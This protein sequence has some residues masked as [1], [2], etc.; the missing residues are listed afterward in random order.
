MMKAGVF[1]NAV[2]YRFY[3]HS[4]SQLRS[5]TCFKREANSDVELDNRIYVLGDFG[6]I[7][8]V[9]KRAK[10]CASASCSLLQTSISNRIQNG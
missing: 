7:M 8:N 10:Q 1:L 3:H 5:R 2:Q 9:A 4:N 6:K